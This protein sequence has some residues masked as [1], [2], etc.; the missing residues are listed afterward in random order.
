MPN[1]T[2]IHS[3]LSSAPQAVFFSKQPTI[4]GIQIAAAAI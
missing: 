3:T 2:A 1:N 4:P